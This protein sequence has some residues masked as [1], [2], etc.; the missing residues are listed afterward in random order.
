VLEISYG[1]KF[2]PL[3]SSQRDD[4]NNSKTDKYEATL[5]KTDE[6]T[7]IYLKANKRSTMN[8]LIYNS[9]LGAFSRA[10]I[11]FYKRELMRDNKTIINKFQQ[12]LVNLALSKYFGDNVSS[13]FTNKDEYVMMM[14]AV[15]RLL[16]ASLVVLP[17]IIGGKVVR[18]VERKMVNKK[19]M[20]KLQA[21]PTWKRVKA[22]YRNSDIEQRI[23]GYIAIIF[24]S[25]FQFIS[26]EDREL[27]GKR[28]E[29]Q[30]EVVG[31]EFLQFILMCACNEDGKYVEDIYDDSIDDGVF[32]VRDSYNPFIDVRYDK[33]HNVEYEKFFT[34]QS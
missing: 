4:D 16:G 6:D 14:I 20:E 2:I 32:E 26:Y 25:E 31:E 1:Y 24:S 18:L 30:P 28:I 5:E 19:E 34:N 15:K 12:E 7:H 13:G 11:E 27:N 9:G 33:Y 29:I 17:E 3:S 23:M 21:S 8:A 22:L 10:E